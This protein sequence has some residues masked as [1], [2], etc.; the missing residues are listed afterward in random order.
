MNYDGTDDDKNIKFIRNENKDYILKKRANKK[1]FTKCFNKNPLL[2]SFN[3]Y[4][5]FIYDQ[6]DFI[7]YFNYLTN[8]NSLKMNEDEINIL[9]K[10]IEEIEITKSINKGETFIEISKSLLDNINN[11]QKKK[12]LKQMS[13]YLS[14]KK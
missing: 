9:L 14:K 10:N 1:K 5:H 8:K 3:L 7:D 6:G 13:N 11:L 2:N 4:S 12:S